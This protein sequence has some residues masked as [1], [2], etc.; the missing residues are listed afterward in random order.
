MGQNHVGC[1][2]DRY[3]SIS[4]Y[5][6]VHPEKTEINPP[7]ANSSMTPL[8]LMLFSHYGGG[9]VRLYLGDRDFYRFSR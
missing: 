3:V 1:E 4:T 8:R 5:R 6:P 9:A 2:P 7:R